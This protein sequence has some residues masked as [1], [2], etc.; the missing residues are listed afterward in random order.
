M[1]FYFELY[2]A[3]IIFDIERGKTSRSKFLFQ[4]QMIVLCTAN[5]SGNELVGIHYECYLSNFLFVSLLCAMHKVHLHCSKKPHWRGFDSF[6]LCFYTFPQPPQPLQKEGEVRIS[7]DLI[8]ATQ[9]SYLVLSIP[10]H[11]I[12]LSYTILDVVFLDLT[13]R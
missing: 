7:S 6:F 13:N 5:D 2:L 11:D 9:V 8:S 3:K 4:L 12:L 1:Q 10:S